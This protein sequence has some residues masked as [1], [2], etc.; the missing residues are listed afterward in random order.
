MT[1]EQRATKPPEKKKFQPS[2]NVLERYLSFQKQS[3]P[4]G[5]VGNPFLAFEKRKRN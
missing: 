2:R 5:K 4:E 1:P 3:E